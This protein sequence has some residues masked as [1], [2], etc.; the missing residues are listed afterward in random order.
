MTND[1]FSLLERQLAEA[2]ERDITAPPRARYRAKGARLATVGGG[3]PAAVLPV[4]ALACATLI[5]GIALAGRGEEPGNVS[6]T[7]AGDEPPGV[8]ASPPT[9]GPATATGRASTPAPPKELSVYVLNGTTV[10]GIADSAAKELELRSFRL[11]GIGNAA[12]NTTKA[13]RVY[14]DRTTAGLVAQTLGLSGQVE[15]LSADLQA[16]APG[17]NV[18]VLVGAD[19]TA[20]RPARRLTLTGSDGASGAV[21]FTTTPGGQRLDLVATGLPRSDLY[22]VWLV[23]R[24]GKRIRLGF[25]SYDRQRKQVKGVTPLRG[26]QRDPRRIFVTRQTKA[27]LGAP[28]TIVLD[29]RRPSGG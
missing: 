18:V 4:A 17:A 5:V 3:L 23:T 6:G 20:P 11:A 1:F 7:T 19:Y 13:S 2:A 16:Q 9:A 28:G 14:S 15:P 8:L 24:T 10:N 26:E 12:R 21:T 25:T 22:L 29:T 27:Q